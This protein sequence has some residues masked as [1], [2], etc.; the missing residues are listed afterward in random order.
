M[1]CDTALIERGASQPRSSGFECHA[2]LLGDGGYRKARAS[3][4]QRA[5]AV[6][7]PAFA[8]DCTTRG[9]Q[10]CGSQEIS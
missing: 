1:P 7:P 2:F 4:A 10:I 8:A 9:K 6:S 5:D 3:R